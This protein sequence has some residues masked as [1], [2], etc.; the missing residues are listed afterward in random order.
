MLFHIMMSSF[1]FWNNLCVK[2]SAHCFQSHFLRTYPKQGELEGGHKK[3]SPHLV[4]SLGTQEDPR[5]Q[6]LLGAYPH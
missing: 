1:H 6:L 2:N 3:L 5:H 4:Q